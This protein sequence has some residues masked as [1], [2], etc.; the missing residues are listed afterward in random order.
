[1]NFPTKIAAG[2]A[3]ALLVSSAAIANEAEKANCIGPE[4]LSPLHAGYE[5]SDMARNGS[6]ERDGV[7]LK[8]GDTRSGFGHIRGRPAIGQTRVIY[9]NP[10]DN[11][12]ACREA[13]EAAAAESESEPATEG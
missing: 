7:R 6:F 11:T 4:D 12:R 5:G 1:M 8:D 9:L 10:T 13:E 3:I 2:A